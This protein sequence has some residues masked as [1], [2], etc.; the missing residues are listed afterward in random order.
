M[1]TRYR[2]TP[3]SH[4][5]MSLHLS[6]ANL[7]AATEFQFRHE[8]SVKHIA[9]PSVLRPNGEVLRLDT[10]PGWKDPIIT[11]L[12]DGSLPDDRAEAQKL[13]HL[14]NRYTPRSVFY[15]KSYFKL[16]ANP[17]LRCL[18]SDKARRVMQ[19]NHDGDCENHSGGRSLAHKVINQGYYWPKMFDDAK[20]YVKKC[21]DC[22]RFARALNIPSSDLH[23]L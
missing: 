6:L 15:K 17:Y 10:S 11:Y 21:S 8:I 18:G 12:K 14:A 2:L 4:C 19:K 1:K 13:L 9:N 22:Q 7:G 20:N 5:G 3:N 23:T 16:H